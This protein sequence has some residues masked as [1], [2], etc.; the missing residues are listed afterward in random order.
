MSSVTVVIP[1]YNAAPYLAETLASVAAQS[2]RPDEVLVVDDGSTDETAAIAR[3]AGVRVVS[4]AGRTGASAARNVGIAAATTSLLAFVDADDLWLP[5]HLATAVGMLGR[6]PSAC[7]AFSRIEKF[8]TPFFDSLPEPWRSPIVCASDV[9]T[10]VLPRLIQANC[11]SQS[12]VVARRDAIERAGGYDTTMRYSEDYDLWL[13]V[14]VER[15]FVYSS[16]VSARYRVH[17]GQATTQAH[18]SVARNSWRARARILARLRHV[19][20]PRLPASTE[21]ALQAA[22]AVELGLAWRSG[23]GEWLDALLEVQDDVPGG[24]A[25][26]RRWRFAR[27]TVHGV[28]A[29]RRLVGAVKGTVGQG[30]VGTSRRMAGIEEQR[31]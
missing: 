31:T 10:D 29:V 21:A 1:C 12:T 17:D 9:A 28:A 24:R 20:P 3:A 27:S 22:Y 8:G 18:A 5:D 7:L 23:H 30:S 26:A 14:A 2:R 15:D 11:V 16:R 25:T 13:R 4:T 19:Q 6:H